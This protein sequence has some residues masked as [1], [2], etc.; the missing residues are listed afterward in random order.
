TN[1]N[2]DATDGLHTLLPLVPYKD[3]TVHFD[4]QERV[5][6]YTKADNDWTKLTDAEKTP[7][8]LTDMAGCLGPAVAKPPAA[9]GHP[10]R[11]LTIGHQCPVSLLTGRFP[12]KLPPELR[13]GEAVWQPKG[14]SI[15]YAIARQ[16]GVQSVQLGVNA[17]GPQYNLSYKNDGERLP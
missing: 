5:A 3:R 4:S 6:D 15:D 13:V 2:Y 16:L 10:T 17:Q 7:F 9:S 14:E 8:G 12:M 1:W 11:E